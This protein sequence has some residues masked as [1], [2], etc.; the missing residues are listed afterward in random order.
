MNWKSPVA[1]ELPARALGS[2]ADSFCAVARR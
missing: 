1:D 2:S